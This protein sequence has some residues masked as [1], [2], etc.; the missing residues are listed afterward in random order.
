MVHGL[1]NKKNGKQVKSK[2]LFRH[3]KVVKNEE[4]VHYCNSLL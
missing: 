3:K 2:L 1:I 4:A